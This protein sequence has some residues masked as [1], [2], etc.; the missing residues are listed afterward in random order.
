MWTDLP[1]PAT[2]CDLHTPLQYASSGWGGGRAG[3]GTGAAL[4]SP[5]CTRILAITLASVIAAIHLRRDPHLA[6]FSAG[7]RGAGA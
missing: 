5:R 2:L 1:P 4:S 7:R 6:H 3:M